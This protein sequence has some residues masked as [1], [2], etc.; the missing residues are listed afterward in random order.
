MS[1]AKMPVLSHSG[2]G[3][4]ALTLG[5]KHDCPLIPGEALKRAVPEHPQAHRTGPEHSL[6]PRSSH[7]VR[8][9]ILLN[10]L[11]GN[12]RARSSGLCSGQSCPSQ[13]AWPHPDS[14]SA[15][16]PSGPWPP[17]A[18]SSSHCLRLF[19]FCDFLISMLLRIPY[20]VSSTATNVPACHSVFITHASSL[21]RRSGEHGKCLDLN[22]PAKTHPVDIGPGGC[23]GRP[24][25]RRLSCH[26]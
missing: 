8:G 19:Q 20:E 7:A 22:K 6:G 11:S 9:W 26:L 23:P 25:L 1:Q 2:Q 15:S 12:A 17:Y 13:G 10:S 18:L 14:F 16:L 4:G 3:R 21:S 5:L 24:S